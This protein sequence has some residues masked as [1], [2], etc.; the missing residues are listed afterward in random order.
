MA[1]AT[2]AER[3]QRHR[4]RKRRGVVAVPV[5]VG[6]D[7]ICALTWR[8]YLDYDAS[9][10]ECNVTDKGALAEA[11]QAALGDLAE[12]A[13]QEYLAKEE[14]AG[15]A[16][17][18][19]CERQVTLLPHWRYGQAIESQSYRRTVRQGA[20]TDLQSSAN[21]RKVSRTEA[22]KLLN[23]GVR[24]ANQTAPPAGNVATNSSRR[25][26]PSSIT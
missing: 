12:E 10:D 11:I 5:E 1:A 22:A 18:C 7:V 16:R 24:T 9:D 2:A 20:R 4:D 19:A 8:E 26:S 13:Y 6:A 15:S 17:W 21:L 23:V 3:A 14:A 25:R